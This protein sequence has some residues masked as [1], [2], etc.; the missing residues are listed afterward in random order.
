MKPAYGETIRGEVS[1]FRGT[2]GGFSYFF[3]GS[4]TGGG[5]VGASWAEAMAEAVSE[6][7]QT[8]KLMCGVVE[9]L[10]CVEYID[11]LEASALHRCAKHCGQVKPLLQFEILS[12]RSPNRRAGRSP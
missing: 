7:R 6:N 2:A 3:S 4:F 8:N 12:A 1:I 11:S 10:M 9:D 5:S